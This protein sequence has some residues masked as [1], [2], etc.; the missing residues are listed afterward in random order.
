MTR[1]YPQIDRIDPYL[2]DPLEEVAEIYA[3]AVTDDV[4][5]TINPTDPHDPV[6]RQYI[7]SAEELKTA[8]RELSDP[9]GDDAHSPIK[10]IVHRYPDRVLL[11]PVHVCAVYCRFCFR[12]EMVGPN[13]SEALDGEEL[14]AALDYIRNTPRVWEVI[15]TGGD[16][17]VLSPRRIKNIMAALAEIGHV[18]VIRFHTRVPVADPSRVTDDLVAAL[19]SEK[20]VYVVL[21]CNHENELTEKVRAAAQK[22]L[23]AGIPL[24]SQS[25]LLKGVN[26]DAK[27]LENLFRR[28][29]EMRIKPYYL[30]HPD[31]A[32]G[33]GHFRLPVAQGRSL[34]KKLLGRLSGIA[35]PR[36]V[37]DI[38]GGF[39]K[40][41][42]E[43]GYY[44]DGIVTDWRGEAH[45]YPE[46]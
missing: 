39:G 23:K 3:V 21:H 19:E 18:K 26:D 36:Y 44:H 25:V 22:F 7:P 12:R 42:L 41:P 4:M 11:K 14:Q 10:G 2:P 24:L 30:H 40:V 46:E 16:P 34:V 5:K 28:L 6:A 15:V 1:I 43:D 9:I 33:T 29:V 8:P 37:L 35:Q 31:M 45:A 27:I 20:A 38:P 32:R 13:K 17:L